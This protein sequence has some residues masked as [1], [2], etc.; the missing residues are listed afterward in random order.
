VPELRRTIW[1]L[2]A[3]EVYDDGADGSAATTS[4]NTLFATQGVFVP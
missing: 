4:D 3:V 2:D 1:A